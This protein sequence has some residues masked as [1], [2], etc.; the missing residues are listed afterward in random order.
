MTMAL[1]TTKM[2]EGG[3]IVIQQVATDAFGNAWG[4]SLADSMSGAGRTNEV[5]LNREQEERLQSGQTMTDY[6][7]DYADRLGTQAQSACGCV[8]G[9]RGNIA[10]ESVEVDHQGRRVDG[11]CR[12]ADACCGQ[13]GKGDQSS[14][15]PLQHRPC[16]HDGQEVMHLRDRSRPCRRA[17]A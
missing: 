9:H 1:I 7:D 12:R 8:G 6:G 16:R 15:A 10:L 14:V 17:S 4:S 3:R 2:T 11:G 5:S 13:G